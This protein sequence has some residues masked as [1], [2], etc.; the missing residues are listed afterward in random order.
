MVMACLARRQGAKWKAHA[1]SNHALALE[2]LAEQEGC[3][4]ARV[5][6]WPVIHLQ[7][8]HLRS[9]YCCRWQHGRWCP[10]LKRPPLAALIDVLRE[11]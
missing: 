11:L 1:A 4:H 7:G 5:W 2:G 6:V 10:V 8:I 3:A 9:H